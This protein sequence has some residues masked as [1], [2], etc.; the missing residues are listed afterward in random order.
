MS[1]AD[2]ASALGGGGAPP[3]GGGMPGAA[4]GP[5]GGDTGTDTGSGGDTYQ[6]SLEA[7]QVAEDALKAFIE[8]DPDH[9]DR[10]VAAQCL[11]NIL[12][13]Q[14]SNQES[15]QGGMAGLSRAL[16]QGPQGPMAGAGAAG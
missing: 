7:L 4:G 12:K 14:A 13:L 8:M 16:Q 1:M 2:F 9:G 6:T 10:A 3:D 11:Q 5:P 15:T